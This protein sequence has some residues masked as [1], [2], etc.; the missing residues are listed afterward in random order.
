MTFSKSASA[1]ESQISTACYSSSRYSSRGLLLRSAVGHRAGAWTPRAGRAVAS[2]RSRR[3]R[4][5]ATQRQRAVRRASMIRD[6]RVGR[7]R[8]APPPRRHSARCRAAAL[9]RCLGTA[10][11]VSSDRGRMPRRRSTHQQ[12]LR[13]S[14]RHG[15]AVTYNKSRGGR[16]RGRLHGVA[17]CT[18]M[19]HCTR[20]GMSRHG[21]VYRARLPRLGPRSLSTELRAQCSVRTLQV[22]RRVAYTCTLAMQ[23][24]VW[25]TSSCVDW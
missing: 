20:G 16:P 17:H 15:E 8:L 12:R 3:R 13:R 19:A 10:R 25:H 2:D 18:T 1:F 6:A 4:S 14:T 24:V 5:H 23:R 7:S 22:L 11:V 21:S 9:R